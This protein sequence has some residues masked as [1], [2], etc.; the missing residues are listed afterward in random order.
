MK[1]MKKRKKLNPCSRTF[2]SFGKARNSEK[3]ME[4]EE[5]YSIECHRGTNCS[6]L[7]AHVIKTKLVEDD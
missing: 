2:L 6:L 1:R 7:A 5:G 4:R 3:N